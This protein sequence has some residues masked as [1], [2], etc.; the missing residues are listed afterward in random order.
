M[1]DHDGN[2]FPVPSTKKLNRT[3]HEP[4]NFGSFPSLVDTHTHTAADYSANWPPETG[5]WSPNFGP[6]PAETVRS[7]AAINRYIAAPTHAPAD[8]VT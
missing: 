5:V 1:D 7:L 4:N 3:E 8:S 6:A 2:I